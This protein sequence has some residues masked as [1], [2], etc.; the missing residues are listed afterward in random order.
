MKLKEVIE[1]FQIASKYFKDSGDGYYLDAS[2]DR[3]YLYPLDLPM[4]EE[5]IKRMVELGFFQES[6]ERD[7]TYNPED[8]W[9]LWV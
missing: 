8:G 4:S 2:H 9:S 3:I 6:W 1:G 7:C 5:D